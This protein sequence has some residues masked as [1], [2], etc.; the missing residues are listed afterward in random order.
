MTGWSTGISPWVRSCS[1]ASAKARTDPSSCLTAFSIEPFDCGSHV[2]GRRLK[3]SL[4][5]QALGESPS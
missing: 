4:R 3:H 1:A 2:R 5:A